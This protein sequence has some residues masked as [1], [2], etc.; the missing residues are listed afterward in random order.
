M[1][2]LSPC[3]L[4]LELEPLS[5]EGNP[6]LRTDDFFCDVLG[7]V[8]GG[9]EDDSLI[10]ELFASLVRLCPDGMTGAVGIV[11]DTE[12]GAAFDIDICTLCED[13]RRKNGMEEGVRRFDW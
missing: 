10:G 9:L 11:G 5:N 3:K 1:S 2:L 7:V 12:A 13:E 8:G 4:L 6:K